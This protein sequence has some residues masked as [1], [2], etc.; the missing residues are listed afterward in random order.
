MRRVFAWLLSAVRAA[1]ATPFRRI[2]VRGA[3]LYGDQL[4]HVHRRGFDDTVVHRAAFTREKMSRPEER[5]T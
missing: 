1:I 4:H 2:R 3:T 5:G